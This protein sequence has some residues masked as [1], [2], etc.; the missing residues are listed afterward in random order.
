M[1]KKSVLDIIANLRDPRLWKFFSGVAV[2]G[3]I[4]GP[5]VHHLIASIVASTLIRTYAPIGGIIEIPVLTQSIYHALEGQFWFEPSSVCVCENEKAL[6]CQPTI[7]EARICRG[8]MPF[9]VS[10]IRLNQFNVETYLRIVP[11][12]RAIIAS[13]ILGTLVILIFFVVI[14]AFFIWRSNEKSEKLFLEN[15]LV[16]YDEIIKLGKR[17]AHDIR[18]P[19]MAMD[20]AAEKIND[21]DVQGLIR[22]ASKRVKKI[23]DDILNEYR[24]SN[25]VQQTDLQSL[26]VAIESLVQE[27]ILVTG[28][29]NIILEIPERV[30]ARSINLT[31]QL[32][33]VIRILSNLVN[34][35][36]EA[37]GDKPGIIKLT[38]DDQNKQ[39]VIKISDQAGGIPEIVLKRLEAGSYSTKKEGF[40]IGLSAAKET[41]QQ[42]G[43]QLIIDSRVGHGTVVCIH[44]KTI[45]S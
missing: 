41:V 30:R 35:S 38:L 24:T 26:I 1:E 36:I 22:A 15:K 7:F 27:K 2:F 43:G 4:L 10:D 33:Q 19:I 28:T 32:D 20:I 45:L 31:A 37:Y 42:W 6:F 18:S 9:S 14:A 34:N 21:P 13:S 39:L 16:L 17:V 8:M 44:L 29:Q 11:M 40:G 23:A 25:P 3:V 5:I 12:N